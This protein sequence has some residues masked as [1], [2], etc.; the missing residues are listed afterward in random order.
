DPE[1]EDADRQF[2]A[3]VEMLLTK[4]ALRRQMSERATRN[5]KDRADPD[6][7]VKRYLEVFEVARDHAKR[8]PAG[9]AV[10]AYGN[11]AHWT[12]MHSLVG[13][14]G[15]MRKPVELNRNQA[16]TGSWTLAAA[17]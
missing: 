6:A 15:L 2:G 10:K 13:A 7:C 12:W 4:P 16:I 17:S 5:A 8:A 14:M 1:S 9:S 3:Y 11:L